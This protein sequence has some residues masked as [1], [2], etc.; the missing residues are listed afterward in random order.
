MGI[1][2]FSGGIHGIR[3]FF[4]FLFLHVISLLA[5]CGLR[6]KLFFF[7]ALGVWHLRV[8]LQKGREKGEGFLDKHAFFGGEMVSSAYPHDRLETTAHSTTM[9]PFSTPFGVFLV[10]VH[11]IYGNI[12]GPSD[13]V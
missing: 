10:R 9:P 7:C 4:S 5:A 13:S 2:V 12:F 6:N 11:K 8:T 1:C 3:F